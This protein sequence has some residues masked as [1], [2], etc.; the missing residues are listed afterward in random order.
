MSLSRKLFTTYAR[1]IENGLNLGNYS[2]LI[3]SRDPYRPKLI[4]CT[5]LFNQHVPF[6]SASAQA[7]LYLKRYSRILIPPGSYEDVYEISR[8]SCKDTYAALYNAFQW[9]MAEPTVGTCRVSRK[10][11]RKDKIYENDISDL[12]I[13]LRGYRNVLRDF[14]AA[15]VGCLRENTAEKKFY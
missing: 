10:P 3:R 9:L 8:F 11:R 6:D 5:W 12:A 1:A 15:C 4:P 13:V 14:P 2:L 7:H